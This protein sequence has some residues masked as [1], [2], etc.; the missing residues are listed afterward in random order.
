MY[1]VYVLYSPDFNKIYIGQTSD[2]H[3]R[4]HYHNNG[5]NKGYTAR[6]RPWEIIHRESF[7]T[8]SEALRREKELKSARGRKWIR[9]NL[10]SQF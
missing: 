6:Y 8:R 5:P 3:T 2:L 9:E 1:S 7:D 4:L 10:L